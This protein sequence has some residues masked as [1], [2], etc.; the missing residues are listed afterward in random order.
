VYM[1]MQ[2]WK[3]LHNSSHSIKVPNQTSII[4]TSIQVY[5]YLQK[6]VLFLFPRLGL[7]FLRVTLG[8]GFQSVKSPFVL[9]SEKVRV[10][11]VKQQ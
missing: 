4:R 8:T 3:L 1:Q 11:R 2:L 10:V 9:R 7:L 6:I 5:K